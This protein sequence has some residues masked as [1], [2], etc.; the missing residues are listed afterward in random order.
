[1]S[2]V[3]FLDG[4]GS[5][6]YY[7]LPLTQAF[8]KQGID[9]VY[10]ALPGHP[11]NRQY[12]VENSK[13]LARWFEEQVPEDKVVVMG[14][15]LGADLASILAMTSTKIERLILLD[16]AVTDF[17]AYPLDKELTAAQTHM[18]MMVLDDLENYLAEQAR[19][20]EDWNDVLAQAERAS[21]E[22]REDGKYY[23]ALDEE[24]VLNLLR[25]RHQFGNVL[26]RPDFQTPTLVILAEQPNQLLTEKQSLL[27]KASKEYVSSLVLKGT[28]HQ[29]YLEAP[30]KIVTATRF[31]LDV[32]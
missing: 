7:T 28:S 25:I 16:G 12:H 17:T 23:L 13:D 2:K 24:I 21:F 14:F 29:L 26:T 3:Y 22:K 6:R 32:F 18:S 30:D 10:L 27:A 4:L 1:M 9:L 31:F 19:Q 20:T 15:S 11:N 8:S 5:N